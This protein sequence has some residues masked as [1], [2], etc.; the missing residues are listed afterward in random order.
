MCLACTHVKREEAVKELQ[1]RLLHKSVCDPS[2]SPTQACVREIDWALVDMEGG[3]KLGEGVD[4]DG[5]YTCRVLLPGYDAGKWAIKMLK[6]G[7]VTPPMREAMGI[8]EA[9]AGLVSCVFMTSKAPWGLIYIYM[10]QGPLKRFV[11]KQ[12]Y[13]DPF[14][15]QKAKLTGQLLAGMT[16]VHKGNN[17]HGDLHS[18]NV[19]VSLDRSSVSHT[20]TVGISD[21]GRM[22]KVGHIKSGRFRTERQIKHYQATYKQHPPEYSNQRTGITTYTKEGDI[23][24]LTRLLTTYFTPLPHKRTTHQRWYDLLKEGQSGDASKRPTIQRLN[25][26]FNEWC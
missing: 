10:N 17:V 9:S 25:D 11:A 7:Q 1:N 16:A 12:R 26:A 8:Q 3:T 14:H 2:S 20:I 21:L 5:V 18:S 19:L 13:T 6:S 22:T 4:C 23:Y 24:A 15:N